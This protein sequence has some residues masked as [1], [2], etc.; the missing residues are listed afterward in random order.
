MPKDRYISKEYSS[1]DIAY[2]AGIVDG[3]GS[4]TIGNYSHNKKTGVP[5]YQTI[6]NI[7]NTNK[8]LIDWLLNTFG[9]G[10]CHYT[11]RQTPKISRQA[12][13]RYIATGNRL[14]HICQLILPFVIIKKRQVEIILEMR[15][16]YLPYTSKG[17]I[18]GTQALSQE[19]LDFRYQC[20]LELRSLHCR[21]GSLK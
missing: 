6:L 2:L 4:L 14:T 8:S 11:A 10:Y 15:K 5:H 17:G 13:Y 7:N 18:Q 21:K 3:E 12:I 20:F 19:I 1:T 9:G 16:T